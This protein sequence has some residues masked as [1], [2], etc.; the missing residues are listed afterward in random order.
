[1]IRASEKLYADLQTR[2]RE[3]GDH[4]FC[5]HKI[6]QYF[7]ICNRAVLALNEKVKNKGFKNDKQEILFFRSVKPRFVYL[8]QYYVLLYNHVMFMPDEPGE[9]L[10]YLERNLHKLDRYL[11]EHQWFYSYFQSGESHLDT[12]YFLRPGPEYLTTPGEVLIS[13][14]MAHQELA[15]Y[16][17]RE[18]DK[19]RSV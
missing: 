10:K 9:Q 13:D 17:R 5:L 4:E 7:D 8:Q 18:I 14:I 15:A 6:E 16:T 2:L 3:T 12:K 11:E 19:L 1:M